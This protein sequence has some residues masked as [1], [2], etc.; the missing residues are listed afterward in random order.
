MKYFN[1][2]QLNK[3]EVTITKLR[4]IC[5]TDIRDTSINGLLLDAKKLGQNKR[6]HKRK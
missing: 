4:D 2:K 1:V 3:I 5:G 6:E